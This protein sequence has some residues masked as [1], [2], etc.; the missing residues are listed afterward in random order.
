MIHEIFPHRF[1]NHFVAA[2]AMGDDDIVLYYRDNSLLVKTYN[3]VIE[4]PRKKDF[5]SLPADVKK[6]FLCTI[7][8]VSCFLV[9]DCPET[10]TDGF[11]YKE[12][13]FFRTHQHKGHAWIA[14]V[15]IQ[16]MN[17]YSKNRFCGT[18]GTAT[19]E[20]PDERAIVCPTCNAV[21]YPNISPAIIVAITCNDK[22]LLARNANFTE[23]WYSLIA[24]FVDVGE[25]LEETV[26]REVKEEVGLD[27]TTIR[28]YK[29]QP[30]PFSGSMMIGFIAEANDTQPI[31]C[32]TIEITEAAWFNRGNLPNHP[33]VLSIAGEMI[34]R[35]DRGEL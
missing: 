30:W 11:E 19:I 35:F 13:R 26:K 24:G 7:D 14:I 9:H 20:K 12:I 28:Y 27:V 32:D 25:S 18:C 15:G 6:A 33:P 2:S 21:V 29:S 1:N 22:L 16:V 34:E 8:D 17:W 4:L 23:S 3:D 31:C 10:T 5:P